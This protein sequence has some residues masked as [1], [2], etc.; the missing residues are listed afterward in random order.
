[1]PAQPMQR[2][3]RMQAT[4]ASIWSRPAILRRV[5]DSGRLGLAANATLLTSLYLN[6][7]F[8]I[9][10]MKELAPKKNELSQNCQMFFPIQ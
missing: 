9:T 8:F 5:T 2:S 6:E 4:L 10:M 7:F 3:I 1:M